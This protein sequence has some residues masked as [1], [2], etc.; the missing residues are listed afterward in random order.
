[1]G[2][3]RGTNTTSPCEF[4]IILPK[5]LRPLPC[6]RD[7]FFWVKKSCVWVVLLLVYSDPQNYI[8]PIIY[9]NKII[10]Y[11]KTRQQGFF[12]CH[13]AWGSLP[14]R[15]AR[16]PEEGEIDWVYGARSR[17]VQGHPPTTLRRRAS[18]GRTTRRSPSCSA[19]HTVALL[20]L[21]LQPEPPT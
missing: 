4:N 9:Y 3:N 2:K 6:Q 12:A 19:G 15:P 21:H 13:E 14:G 20:S 17:A 16:L 18:L 7:F 1:M 11:I 10:V 5:E 8:I